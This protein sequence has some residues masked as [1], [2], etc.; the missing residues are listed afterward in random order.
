[1]RAELRRRAWRSVCFADFQLFLV[2]SASVV[3]G[4]SLVWLSVCLASLF[5]VISCC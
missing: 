5:V 4:M 2:A 1:M 3:L